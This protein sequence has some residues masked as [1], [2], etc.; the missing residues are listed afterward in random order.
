MVIIS[1]FL[2]FSESIS[3]IIRREHFLPSFFRF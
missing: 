1:S 2:V 3:L